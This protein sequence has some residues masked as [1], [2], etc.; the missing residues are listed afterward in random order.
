MNRVQVVLPTNE[1]LYLRFMV[2]GNSSHIVLGKD[3]CDYFNWLQLLNPISSSYKEE[4]SNQ[5]PKPFN[6]GSSAVEDTNQ[7]SEDLY[8][9]MQVFSIGIMDFTQQDFHEMMTRREGSPYTA[10][11]PLTP[12]DEEEPFT[13]GD[14]LHDEYFNMGEINSEEYPIPQAVLQPGLQ[15]SFDVDPELTTSNISI[16]ECASG[17]KKEHSEKK[18]IFQP[19]HH[20]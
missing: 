9:G 1:T 10:S 15:Q 16:P 3:F 18:I 12:L 14:L 2:E 6:Q 19:S 5:S 8:E 11:S 4:E 13:L 20:L 7:S 17:S